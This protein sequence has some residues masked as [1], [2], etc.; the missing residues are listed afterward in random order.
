[1]AEKNAEII[2]PHEWEYRV[3]CECSKYDAAMSKISGME[4]TGAQSTPGA[5]S[6]SGTYKSLRLTF[7]AESKEHAEKIGGELK[8]ID[9]VKFIL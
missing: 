2:F 7:I 5:V 9:G 8:K 6:K 4:L 1:M 3:F